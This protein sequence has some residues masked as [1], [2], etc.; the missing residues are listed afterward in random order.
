LEYVLRIRMPPRAKKSTIPNKRCL[1]I[2]G[3]GPLDD[4]DAEALSQREFLP[5]CCA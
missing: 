4:T 2:T 3:G 5:A 1:F